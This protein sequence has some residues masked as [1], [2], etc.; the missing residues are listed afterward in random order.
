MTNAPAKPM[1]LEDR[2]KKVVDLLYD[3]RCK[4]IHEGA[5]WGLTFHDGVTSMISGEPPV[6]VK[7][8]ITDLQRIVV[9]GCIA[10]ITRKLSKE[11]V[12]R[13]AC[14]L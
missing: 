12:K 2:L 6:E 8:T 13:Q 1:T 3:T 7:I 11:M 10:A 5:T 4:L 9:K 14:D